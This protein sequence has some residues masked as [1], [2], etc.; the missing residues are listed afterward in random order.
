M[1]C[2]GRD[3]H[4]IEARCAEPVDLH[5]R[6]V[7]AIARRQHR[8]AGD[9]GAGFADGVDAAQDHVVDLSFVSSAV[10]SR[11]AVKRRLGEAD[12][13]DT[14]CRPPSGFAPT[15]RRSDGIVDE[16][17]GHGVS[18]WFGRA[19]RAY[20]VTKVTS[21]CVTVYMS[22]I[23]GLGLAGYLEAIPCSSPP[24][25]LRSTR[26]RSRC[27]SSA[28]PAPAART[29]TRSRP[30]SSCASI[31]A[32]AG[33]DRRELSRLRL[34]ALAGRRMTREGIIVLAGRPVPHA[35]AEP[36]GC[37][38]AA[39]RSAA[40]RGRAATGIDVGRRA[41]RIRSAADEACA[42]SSTAAG[43]KKAQRRDLPLRPFRYRPNLTRSRRAVA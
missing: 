34:A 32:R 9:V 26:R 36:V 18:A 25:H 42:T 4:G 39:G 16:S 1:I 20:L 13:R 10:R 35:G 30:R 22:T 38:G 17:V 2:D 28:R 5:A 21:S 29:S 7:V 11:S 6:H 14:S 27:A 40:A 19:G 41:C 37:A 15:A 3:V 12:R 31:L 33:V 23:I 24:D 43:L 8:G